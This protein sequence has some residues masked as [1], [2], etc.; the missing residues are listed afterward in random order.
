MDLYSLINGQ[1]NDKDALNKLGQSVGAEPSQV[2]QLAQIGLPAL[3]QALGRNAETTEGA[4]SLAA[5]LDQHQDD[6]VEDINGFLNKVD[7]EDGA[8]I[9]NHIFSGRTDRVQN[10][11]ARQTGLQQSQ[12]SGLMTQLAPLLLGMLAKQKKEKNVEPSALPGLLGA[13]TSQGN[14]G[15]M[16]DLVSNLLDADNDGSIVDDVGNLLKGFFKK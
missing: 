5:A 13:F 9:L 14:N 1:L 8:K 4:V 16:M 2:Q 15:G 6:D 3:L 7:K 12:V 11:L 10:N